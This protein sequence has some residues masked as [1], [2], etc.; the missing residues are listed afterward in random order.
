MGSS[1]EFLGDE[2]AI[3]LSFAMAPMA[4]C[5]YCLGCCNLT[6]APKARVI[7]MQVERVEDCVWACLHNGS[8]FVTQLSSLPERGRCRLRNSW[9]ACSEHSRCGSAARQSGAG[10][11][12]YRLSSN[13]WHPYPL[14]IVV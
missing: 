10:Q 8:H 11:A 12:H 7:E 3:P 4:L 6:A 2:F 9:H 1:S 13:D 14:A 5:V